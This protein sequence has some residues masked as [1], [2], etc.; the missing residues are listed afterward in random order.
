M[1]SAE[2]IEYV[3]ISRPIDRKSTHI[4]RVSGRPVGI[5][6]AELHAINPRRSGILPGAKCHRSG[7]EFLYP[8]TESK[9]NHG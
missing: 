5:K 7:E 3:A 2:G 1:S 4:G 9:K 6:T 8:G